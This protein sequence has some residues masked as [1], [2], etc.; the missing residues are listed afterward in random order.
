MVWCVFV[1]D[2]YLYMFHRFLKKTKSYISKIARFPD[3]FFE[4]GASLKNP[5]YF[6]FFVFIFMKDKYT[7]LPEA[8]PDYAKKGSF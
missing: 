2:G 4:R 7:P 5:M 8:G 1:S 3:I 6:Y